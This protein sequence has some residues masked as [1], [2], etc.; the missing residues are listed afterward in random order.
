LV[1]DQGQETSIDTISVISVFI[2]ILIPQLIIVNKLYKL[3]HG[4]NTT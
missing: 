3:E 2:I 1:K 4:R